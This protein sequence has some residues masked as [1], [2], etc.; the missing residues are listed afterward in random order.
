MSCP[1]PTGKD[2]PSPGTTGG[3]LTWA[4]SFILRGNF[5]LGFLLRRVTFKGQSR[6]AVTGF[7]LAPEDSRL[8]LPCPDAAIRPTQGGSGTQRKHDGRSIDLCLYARTLGRRRQ[9]EIH[10][11]I[12]DDRIR[13]ADGIS[14]LPSEH[15]GLQQK[16]RRIR[17]VANRGA[18]RAASS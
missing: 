5:L 16:G 13:L 12:D 15:V 14:H 7:N 10:G 17:P 9:S 11:L 18:D 1:P 8:I 3:G 6:K 4:A 2:S